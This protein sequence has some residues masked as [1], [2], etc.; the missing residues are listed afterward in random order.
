MVYARGKR[1]THFGNMN[2]LQKIHGFKRFHVSPVIFY[3]KVVII[4]MLFLIAT[5]S[6]QVFQE[7]V[8]VDTDYVL[9]LDSSASMAK[10]DYSPNRL[11]AAKQISQNWLRSLDRETKIGYASFSQEIINEE[12]LT[13]KK[14]LI[15][16]RIQETNI[17][18]DVGGTSLD[19][20]LNHAAGFF[21]FGG[22]RQK[23]ILLLTD[24]A[25]DV[26]DTT[27]ATL[28]VQGIQVF[29]FGIGAETDSVVIP[30]EYED[31]YADL[32]FNFSQ[33]ERVSQITGGAAYRVENET[34]L[35][36]AIKDATLDQIQVKLNS[37][38]Y[39]ML[40]IALLSILELVFYARLGGL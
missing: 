35:A 24:A 7:R 1:A 12:P 11:A 20:A 26:Q 19:F 38:Y 39:I 40:L 37:S 22:N 25:E 17:N 27:L 14:D 33:L 31:F 2:L 3:V 34:S 10:A 21:D 29:A 36:R 32:S 30:E 5:G 18:Y 28:R 15:S 8:S 13:T 23:A 4:I 6:L 9:L 16:S